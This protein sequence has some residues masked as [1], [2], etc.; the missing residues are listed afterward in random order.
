MRCMIYMKATTRTSQEKV[1]STYSN[2]KK[3]EGTKKIN[4]YRKIMEYTSFYAEKSCRI[5]FWCHKKS[6]VT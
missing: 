6:M 1:N 3:E 2:E 5:S 4:N